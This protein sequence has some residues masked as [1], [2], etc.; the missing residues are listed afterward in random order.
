VGSS[1]EELHLEATAVRA[2][3]TAALVIWRNEA[4]FMQKQLVLQRARE[5]RMTHHALTR[6]IEKKDVLM[7]TIVHDLSAP[8]HSVL[9]ALS[10][11]DEARLDEPRA[12]WIKLALSAAMRQRQLIAEILDVFSLEQGAMTQLPVGGDDAPDVVETAELVIAESEPVAR[13]RDVRIEL[14]RPGAWGTSHCRAVAEK[15]RLFRVLTN[16][17]DNALRC[18]PGGGVVAIDVSR[19]DREVIV[20]V[21]DDGPGV[22]PELKPELF[23]KFAKGRGAGTGLGLY[24]C[25]ITVEEWGGSIGYEERR[26]HGA[27][28]WVRMIAAKGSSAPGPPAGTSGLRHG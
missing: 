12:Q 10:L 21:D 20:V 5:L 8:L 13:R 7:H 28:F 27:R 19:G 2:G 14:R 24:F 17:V 3:P 1:G 4:L 16:L 15:S 18:S 22:P 9:G 11:L 6:E 25:R 23:A 26:P